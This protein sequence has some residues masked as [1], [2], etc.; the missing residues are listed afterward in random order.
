VSGVVVGVVPAAVV[1][2]SA[3]VVAFGGVS[4]ASNSPDARM[5]PDS[6]APSTRPVVPSSGINPTLPS[7][8]AIANEPSPCR[9][10]RDDD[11]CA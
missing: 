4:T 3:G 6:P 8:H 5:F 2:L 1:A 9:S 7:K 10:I 11:C